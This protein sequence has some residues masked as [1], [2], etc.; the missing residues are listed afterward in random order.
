MACVHSTTKGISSVVMAMALSRDYFELD[1]P[2]ASYW[3][4]FGS[5]GK[6][7]ITA[8]QIFDH[9]AGLPIIEQPHPKAASAPNDELMFKPSLFQ[10][11]FCK[12]GSHFDMGGRLNGYFAPGA[13]G[14]MSFADPDTGIG[15]GYALNRFG[16]YLLN[17]PRELALREA[18]FS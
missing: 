17:D 3:Q 8:R 5:N 10:M 16:G 6:E 1:A 9:S 11:G 7:A 12:P 2:I 13:G 4:E 14:N 18:V 15:F